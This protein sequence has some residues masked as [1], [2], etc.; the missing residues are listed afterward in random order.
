MNGTNAERLAVKP[1]RALGKDDALKWEYLTHMWDY[2]I[3]SPLRKGLVFA[4]TNGSPLLQASVTHAFT[5]TILQLGL[6]GIGFHELRPTHA[7]LVLCQG[8]NR[9]VLQER[10][11]HSTITQRSIFMYMLRWICKK[12]RHYGLR[13]RLSKLNL[14]AR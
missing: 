6:Q 3:A 4:N 5:K 10:S 9:K 1:T 13:K 14:K 11:G 12:R 7:T 8:V 2:T